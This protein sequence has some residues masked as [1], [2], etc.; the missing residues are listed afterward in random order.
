MFIEHLI[1]IAHSPVA[2]R[3]LE[4]LLGFWTGYAG[5]PG[6]VRSDAGV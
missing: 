1:A 2:P 5:V 6:L 4:T 3:S